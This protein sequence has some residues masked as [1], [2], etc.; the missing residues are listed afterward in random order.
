MNKMNQK[1]Q[2]FIEPSM[3]LYLLVL[4]CFVAVS[5]FFDWRLAAAEGGLVLILVIYSMVSARRKRRE[6]VEYIESVTYNVESAQ[7]STLLNFPLP[8]VVFKLDE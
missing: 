2:K 6:L 3:R 1:L 7:N 8:I 4:V 5:V